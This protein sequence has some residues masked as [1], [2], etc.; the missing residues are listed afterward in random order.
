MRNVMNRAKS[1]QAKPSFFTADNWE[2]INTF[3]AS[4]Q[5]RQLCEQN[6][7]NRSS[8]SSDGSATYAGGSINIAE[9]RKRLAHELGTEPTFAA[10]FER[11]F[12][13][14]DKTWTGDRAKAVKEKYDELLMSS[15][16]GSDDCPESRPP[17]DNMALWMEATGGGRAESVRLSDTTCAP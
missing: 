5:S 4:E 13:K 8:S 3:W 17:V 6:K 9:H 7:K 15:A 1:K 2:A 16:S 11:T 14:K 10:T 12:Q